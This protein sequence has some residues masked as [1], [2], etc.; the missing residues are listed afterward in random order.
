[1]D[2]IMVRKTGLNSTNRRKGKGAKRKEENTNHIAVN[3]E[4]ESGKTTA[5][6]GCTIDVVQGKSIKEAT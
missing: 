3:G 4:D 1:M 6:E 5:G 2:G